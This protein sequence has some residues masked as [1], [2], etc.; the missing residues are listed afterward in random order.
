MD[1]YNSYEIHDRLSELPEVLIV[2]ILSLLPM[3]Q[4]VAT[5]LLSKRWLHLWTTVPCLDFARSFHRVIF[6]NNNKYKYQE[7]VRGALAHWKGSKIKKFN[8][9]FFIDLDSSVVAGIAIFDSALLFAVEKQV[10]E[11]YVCNGDSRIDY[12]PPQRL[13][14]CSSITKMSIFCCELRIDVACSGMGSR[15]LHFEAQNG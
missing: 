7:F 13:Y 4:V 9:T 2:E 5:M 1:S 10:E 15:V 3:T 6:D 12:C 14:S 11:L 8:L